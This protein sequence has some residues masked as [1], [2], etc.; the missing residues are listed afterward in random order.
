MSDSFD[1]MSA[2]NPA[3]EH[4]G[5]TGT[6]V[7]GGHGEVAKYDVRAVAIAECDAA[8]AAIAVAMAAG[9]LPGEIVAM[10]LSTQND[11]F[12]VDADL[13]VPVNVP[14]VRPVRISE[15]HVERLDRAIEHYR[16]QAQ[17]LDGL[18][19]PGGTVAS[20]LLFQA[21]ATVRR[22]ERAVWAAVD[23]Y[24]ETVNAETGRYLNHLSTL[25]FTIARGANAE[26]GDVVWVP[27]WSVAPATDEQ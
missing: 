24:P 10:L 21:R 23:Q 27:G 20:A 5:D 19:L 13:A 18:V 15:D 8:N 16:E 14:E 3:D 25:L 22:A 26:H 4:R 11:L 12:D 9:G 2:N 1:P 6:I 7:L 17:D